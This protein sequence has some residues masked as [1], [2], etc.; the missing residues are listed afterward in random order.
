MAFFVSSA[1]GH[2]WNLTV[3]THCCC[4]DVQL[5]GGPGIAGSCKLLIQKFWKMIVKMKE[6]APLI[7]LHFVWVFLML[8]EKF[9][10][11]AEVWSWCKN[12]RLTRSKAASSLSNVLLGKILQGKESLKALG[13]YC[14]KRECIYEQC[15]FIWCVSVMF[16]ECPIL[17]WRWHWAC[18][19]STCWEAQFSWSGLQEQHFPFCGGIVLTGS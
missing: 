11:P 10:F 9:S 16:S 12:C 3:R 17:S 4:C 2:Q 18:M 14:A 1:I 15:Y 19:I 6:N 8:L 13:K 7:L 5:A